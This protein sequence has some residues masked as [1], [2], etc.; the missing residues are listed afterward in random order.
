MAT[1]RVLED[2]ADENVF[3]GRQPI[4]DRKQEL[5]AFELLFRSG[6]HN[7]AIVSDESQATATVITNAF[8]HLGIE[9]ALGN[10]RAFINVSG[11]LLM[12]D[13]IEML[14]AGKI[15]LEI[16]ETVEL[17]PEVVARCRNL[18]RMGFALAI[19]DVTELSEGMRALLPYVELVKIDLMQ[20]DL[21]QIA[22][23]AHAFAP[24]KAGLLAEKVETREQ[25]EACLALGFEFFQGYYFA[26]P[27]I[28]SGKKLTHSEMTLLELL[29]LVLS[30]GEHS[31][32]ETTLKRDPGLALN[33]MRLTNSVAF[34][35][36]QP[37]R[38]L[39]SAI[40]ILGR[41]Q[42]QRWLQI[43][44]YAKSGGK[45]PS[46]LLQMAATRAKTM[47]LLAGRMSAGGDV[48]DLAFMTG[49]MS[50]MDV[51]LSSPLAEL[52]APMP[53]AIEVKDALLLRSGPLGAL[54]SVCE[55]IESGDDT[56]LRT[57]LG[58][59]PG[60]SPDAVAFAQ[61]EAMRWANSLGEARR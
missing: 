57:V 45:L 22:E 36:G 54:L 26:K 17:T 38:T 53:L 14:P 28:V 34:G 56:G 30:D 43:L 24:W 37:V 32:I 1:A 33:L 58:T 39:G 11:D 15:V 55:H 48:E 46:P 41:R 29:G 3:L 59:L 44:L 9:A 35:T 7:A 25:M 8:S 31:D 23:L 5:Y 52:I 51:L 19:D 49:I 40:M 10:Y 18:R 61:T 60:V 47:E 13:A 16:L 2:G 6:M 42:L 21:A 50:L 12:S 20:L 27:Q 4:L